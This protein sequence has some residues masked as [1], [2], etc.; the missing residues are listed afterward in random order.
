MLN[1]KYKIVKEGPWEL[2]KASVV[3]TSYI[4]KHQISPI[5]LHHLKKQK[6]RC[7]H[8]SNTNSKSWVKKETTN[9]HQKWYCFPLVF[10]LSYHYHVSPHHSIFLVVYIFH[11]SSPTWNHGFMVMECMCFSY[12]RGIDGAFF[13]YTLII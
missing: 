6:I 10:I 5:W 9:P 13:F 12:C 4:N 7:G 8:A 11:S 3:W 1:L 2:Y